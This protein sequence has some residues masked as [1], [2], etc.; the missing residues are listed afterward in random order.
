MARVVSGARDAVFGAP[1]GEAAAAIGTDHATTVLTDNEAQNPQAPGLP[2]AIDHV[3][4]S[5]GHPDRG[6]GNSGSDATPG[7]DS[8]PDGT[9]DVSGQGTGGNHQGTHHGHHA[10]PS[11]GGHGQGSHQNHAGGGGAGTHAAGAVGKGAGS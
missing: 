7:G 10:D 2:N 3:T 4:G 9:T 11:D 1:S 8:N 6:N 5:G